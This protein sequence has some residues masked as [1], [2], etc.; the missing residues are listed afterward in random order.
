MRSIID[1]TAE[2]IETNDG[3]KTKDDARRSEDET[4][5]DE[6]VVEF[7]VSCKHSLNLKLF[8]TFRTMSL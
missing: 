5:A 8:L 3:I 7:E 2:N 1:I 4:R 6:K